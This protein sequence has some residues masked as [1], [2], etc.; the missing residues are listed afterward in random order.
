[1]GLRDALG[2]EL[3]SGRSS[4]ARSI[5]AGQ[6][7]KAVEALAEKH[8]GALGAVA[9]EHI[10][11]KIISAAND[12]RLD[13]LTRRDLREGAR[14]LFSE[15][16]AFG[17]HASTR[18]AFLTE[19][20]K[21]GQRSAILAVIGVYFGH[22]RPKDEA[23]S[24]LAAWC[25]ANSAHWH[26]RDADKWRERQHQW[27][28]FD[29]VLGPKTLAET[30]LNG[31]IQHEVL[32]ATGLDR[33]RVFGGFGEAAFVVACRL[34]EQAPIT[35]LQALQL[36]LIEWGH[37]NGRFAYDA[38]WPDYAKTL[39]EPWEPTRKATTIPEDHKTTIL[40]ELIAYAGDPRTGSRMRW[41][42][43][44]GTLAKQ[45]VLRWLTRA[46]VLQFL[47]IVDRTADRRMWAFRRAFW[48]SYLEANHIDAAWVAF[49]ENGVRLATEAAKHSDDESMRQYGRVQNST[50]RTPDHAALIMQIGDLVIADWSH[51][52]KYNIWRK[53]DRGAPQL[54]R[55]Q[56]TG[57]ELSS[58]PLNGSH[59]SP[60]TFSWQNR[61]AAEIKKYTGRRVS[62]DS[63]YPKKRR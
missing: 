20:S 7:A 56:Y 23:I 44:D 59:V 27:H 11:N 55:S 35:E 13:D 39:V 48:T 47:D 53:G 38:A 51:K 8:R 1:M 9:L 14:G 57:Y 37:R 45:I 36:R 54:F 43:L 22:F 60:D 33:D 61:V 10:Q 19:V 31:S 46:S 49:G 21:R 41:S 24:D 26:F 6:L 3:D 29:V 58:G 12:N 30:L 50:G 15:P 16:R 40:N 25:R 32:V 2:S 62:S 34:I 17:R 52:G 42:A 5:S 4:R 28:V 63:W 18:D